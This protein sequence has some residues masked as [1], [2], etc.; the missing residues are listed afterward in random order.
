MFREV[1]WSFVVLL[2]VI[3]SK[4]YLEHEAYRR[5]SRC[6]V[7]MSC[8]TMTLLHNDVVTDPLDELLLQLYR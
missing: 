2:D 4:K 6:V 1:L 5:S 8:Y 3:F 7:T